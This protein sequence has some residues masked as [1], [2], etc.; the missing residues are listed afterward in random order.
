MYACIS[1]VRVF[2]CMLCMSVYHVCA[3]T[4]EY[5]KSQKPPRTGVRQLWDTTWVLE[6]KPGSSLRAASMTFYTIEDKSILKLAQSKTNLLFIIII[7]IIISVCVCVERE[8][9]RERLWACICHSGH[10]DV[11]VCMCARTRTAWACRNHTTTFRS[12]FCHCGTELRAS[13]EH[14]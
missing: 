9:E 3:C 10:M 7:I 1:C 4:Q 6:S 11:I 5:Q 13:E 12:Q 8:R 14:T 2:A